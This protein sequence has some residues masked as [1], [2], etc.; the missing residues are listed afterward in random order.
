MAG[1]A[2]RSGRRPKPTERKV[3]TG[4]PGKRALNNQAPDFG[5]VVNVDPPEWLEGPGRE[6][7]LTLAPQLCAQQVLQGTDIQ[8]L[9]VYCAAYGNFRRAQADLARDGPVVA[10]A[11][12]G[13][14]KNPAATVVNESARQMA[15]Y[16]SLL[17]LDP[18]S[19]QRL[20]GPKKKSG[21]NPFAA[22]LTR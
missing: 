7:W 9:E 4:N 22:L 18:S 14:T 19:R 13:P 6:L 20:M 15:T 3:A 1:V 11:Q 10:G 12:G 17:G 2:G 16:G 21:E 8:N 5:R